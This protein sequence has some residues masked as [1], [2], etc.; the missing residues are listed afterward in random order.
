MME[1][2]CTSD[3]LSFYLLIFVRGRSVNQSGP[4]SIE[5]WCGR[6]YFSAQDVDQCSQALG[7]SLG[8]YKSPLHFGLFAITW[9]PGYHRLSV[10][11]DLTCFILDYSV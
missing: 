9:L 6:S 7:I 3:T 5:F 10:A 4:A 2:G 11:F 1:G 8:N